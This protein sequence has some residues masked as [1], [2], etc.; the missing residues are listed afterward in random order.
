M[1]SHE[2]IDAFRKQLDQVDAQGAQQIQVSALRAYLDALEKDAG[3]SREYRNREHAGMLAQYAAKNS[4]SIEML[5]AVL[6]A[7]KSALH[8]LLIINGGAVVALL[9]VMSNLAGKASGAALAKYLA[10]PLL[11]FGIGVLVGAVGFAFRYFS[12]ACYSESENLQDK[13]HLWGD[14]FRYA[15][16]ASAFAGYVLFGFAVVNAYHSVV[17]SFAP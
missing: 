10:L 8:A 6:E 9:G 5:K 2:V 7:G 16:I 3:A 4:Y 17:W 11:Q 13:Y 12:Q 1:E 15:A 14:R